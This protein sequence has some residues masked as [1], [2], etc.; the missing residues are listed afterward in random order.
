MNYSELVGYLGIEKGDSI[1]L[2]SEIIRL[3]LKVKNTGEKFDPN[4]FI[5]EI[6]KALGESGTL[7]IPTFSFEFCNKGHYDM[8]K[9]KGTTG[10]LGNIAL[11]RAD[12]KRTRHPMHS[13]AVW[14]RDKEM[15]V[16][17]NNLHSF[18]VDSPFAYCMRNNVKQ[19]ILGTDY[20]HAMTFVHYA[21]VVCG[22]PYRFSKSFEGIYV[23]EKGFAEKRKYDYS[24]RILEICPEE[25]FNLMGKKL[26]EK[27]V[28][29]IIYANGICCYN[30]DLAKSFP[31]ICDDI[32][33]NKCRNI[34][35]F[36]ISRD[37]IFGV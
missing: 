12:F 15:L 36:N 6:Q 22:V 11:Q 1:W 19:I 14:G 30:I 3:A 31:Y 37:E 33:N 24:A 8:V 28:S 7:L 26:E 16:G 25:K 4:L 18:G 32:I 35:D 20:V 34:Y 17:M 5:D 27:G 29:R 13:F 21:E 2:S 23:D 9:S 10:A